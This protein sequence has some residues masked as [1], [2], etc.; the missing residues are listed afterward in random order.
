MRNVAL[1]K[2]KYYING[3]GFERSTSEF[4]DTTGSNEPS[5]PTNTIR[6]LGYTYGLVNKILK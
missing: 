2:I 1:I 4:R 3:P 5:G 6:I